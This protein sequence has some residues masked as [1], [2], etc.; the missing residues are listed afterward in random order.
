MAV[1]LG[2]IRKGIDSVRKLLETPPIGPDA[3][4]LEI[5][6]AVVDAIENL[7]AVVGVGRTSF[8][9]DK[10]VVRL[11]APT[12]EEKAS[13]E[14]VFAELESRVRER[15]KERRCDVP[16]ALAFS[17]TC[18]RKVPPGWQP[19]QRFSL[20]CTPR[21]DADTVQAAMLPPTLKIAVVNGTANRKAFSFREQTILIGRT[22]QAINGHHI[23][24]NQVAFDD[25][26][27]TV[28]RGHARLKYDGVRA[29]YRVL[30]DGSA[31]GTWI[32]R[33]GASIPVPHDPRGVRIKSGDEV[34]L[35]D[36]VLRVTID[37]S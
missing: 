29:E 31:R 25:D 11:F 34:H 4:P 12:K 37:P 18:V 33:G 3:P 21:S 19:G 35:G 30:D 6:A 1:K 7:I 9:F 32:V 24:R 10:V 26:N 13:L 36:A 14:P 8:P 20:D 5:R 23:R 27:T 22:V 2:S 17:V 15:F 16:R 28:S